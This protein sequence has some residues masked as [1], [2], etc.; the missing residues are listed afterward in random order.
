MEEPGGL[1]SM[2]SQTVR[3]DWMTSLTYSYTGFP[4]GTSGKEP[5]CQCRRYER[6]GFDPG[7][8][9]IPWGGHG[10][11]LQSSCLENPM[12]KR[13]LWATVH[14]VT[15]GK[16]RLKQLSMHTHILPHTHI[17]QWEKKQLLLQTTMWINLTHV[18]WR[19]RN[20]T[21]ESFRRGQCRWSPNTGK[22]G[23]GSQ[24]KSCLW[25]LGIFC[26]GWKEPW[27]WWKYSIA[28]VGWWQHGVYTHFDSL[29]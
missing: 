28:W 27:G 17:P 29:N 21:R 10:N 26:K 25:Q 22:L 15:T 1:Q 24:K 14:G 20:R 4:D 5:A 19:E 16:T 12:D 23:D 3:H 8:G 2:G 9:K 13:A 6:C 18:M 7:V 11:P